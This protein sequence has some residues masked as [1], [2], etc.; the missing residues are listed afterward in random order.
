M[1]QQSPPETTQQDTE[2]Q[3]PEYNVGEIP[4]ADED[5]PQPYDLQVQLDDTGRPVWPTQQADVQEQAQ[6]PDEV[7]QT[8]PY[9]VEETPDAEAMDAYEAIDE[10]IKN[11]RVMWIHYVTKPKKPKI[12]PWTG[13]QTV[14]RVVEPH[15]VYHARTTG[16]NILVV[17]DRQANDVR[18]FIIDRIKDQKYTGQRFSKRF[19]VTH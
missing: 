6:D 11:N 15:G 18:A 14:L 17:Y 10:A 8:D 12:G 5:E 2:Q 4:F 13:N 3:L 7:Q 9:E 1:A 16:N 19:V